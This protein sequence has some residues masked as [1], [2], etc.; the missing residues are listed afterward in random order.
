VSPSIY[1]SYPEGDQK[2][3]DESADAWQSRGDPLLIACR[4]VGPGKTSG[5]DRK[6]DSLREGH[7]FR[8]HQ[9]RKHQMRSRK[10]SSWPAASFTWFRCGSKDVVPMTR[11][12]MNSRPG[13]GRLFKRLGTRH[14]TSRVR[15]SGAF[16]AE[17]SHQT[18]QVPADA[19]KKPMSQASGFSETSVP[20]DTELLAL[21]VI[22]AGAIGE[23][24]KG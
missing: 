13:N 23:R 2:V 1:I 18:R 19:S 12:L 14:R 7:A 15:R 24:I 22:A 5:I 4:D 17:G 3:A 20:G 11:L 16:L 10:S 8:I 9:Q 21:P 6:G